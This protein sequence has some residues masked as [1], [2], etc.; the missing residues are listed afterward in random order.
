MKV[1][2]VILNWNTREYLGHWL[3]ALI[4]SCAAVPGAE[5]VVADNGSADGS[6]EMMGE[7]FPM[8]RVLPL[9]GNFGFTG[10]YNR[11]L[12]Q[13]DAE[14]FVL[15]NSDVE[16]GTEWL[17]PLVRWMD[18]HPDCA[19]CGPKLHSLDFEGGSYVRTKRFEYAGASGGYIDRFGYP[20]CRGRV[21]GRTEF[22]EGQY[23]AP[24]DVM[25]VSGACMMTRASV[26]RA[27]GGLDDRFFAHMEEI[28]YCWRAQLSGWKVTVVPESVVWHLGGGTLPQSSPFKLKLNYRN[29]LLML[30]KNLPPTVGEGMASLRIIVRKCLDFCSALVYLV[31]GKPG[32]A[33]A[34]F[35]AHREFNHLKQGEA[36]A[37]VGTPS[38]GTD[39]KVVG[40]KEINIVLQAILRGNRIFDYLRRYENNH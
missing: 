11:A 26:W 20:F 31:S 15:I 33:S 9:G 14:Y 6:V 16:V 24:T 37:S 2:V 40:Y 21:M 35:Q 39:V 22:D 10:G 18:G 12:A 19:V 38:I 34:V 25:W 29:N 28:D 17:G 13:L 5:V 32:Y 4:A 23:D 8:V 30:N 1:A 36:G 27:L 7:S 3:P